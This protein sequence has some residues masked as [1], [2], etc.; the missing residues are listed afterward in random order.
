MSDDMKKIRE[1]LSAIGTRTH[2]SKGINVYHV[3]PINDLREHFTEGCECWCHPQ[4]DGEVIIH[5][6][7]DSRED[8]ETG[9]R[10]P[11]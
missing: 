7:M 8:Y 10:K 1:G 5:N 4:H 3:Y 9:A 2:S 6:S 11:S